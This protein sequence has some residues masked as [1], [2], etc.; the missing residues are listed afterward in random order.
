MSGVRH[1]LKEL[2][3]YVDGASRGNP[4]RAGIGLAIY[5][6]KGNILKRM[7]EYIGQTTNNVAEY[8]ALI[9]GLQEALILN[10]TCLTIYTDSQLITRQLEGSYRVKDNTL[11]RFYRQV[12]HLIRGFDRVSIEHIERKQNKEADRLAN[13]AIDEMG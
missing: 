9:W 4:G 2:A 1:I 13:R 7:N 3:I 11:R 8:T 12:Q 6:N 5:D 10:A